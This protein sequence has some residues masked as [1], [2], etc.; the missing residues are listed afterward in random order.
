MQNALF[1]SHIFGHKKRNSR[2]HQSIIFS[3]LPFNCCTGNGGYSP[4]LLTRSLM[5]SP[6]ENRC[7]QLMNLIK[8]EL[9][10]A[11]G[12][13]AA[14]AQ[15]PSGDLIENPCK[16]PLI[17]WALVDTKLLGG[18]LNS[19]LYC[20]LPCLLFQILCWDNWWRLINPMGRPL[21]LVLLS[22]CFGEVFLVCLW[23]FELHWCF[24]SGCIGIS[25]LNVV[26]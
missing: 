12:C 1:W 25:A 22:T 2:P 24:D 6:A 21:D 8:P 14:M 9:D 4:S 23:I 5:F 16:A 13:S 17:S 26:A 15:L 20:W 7:V 19:L 10:L 11:L 18:H 3:S